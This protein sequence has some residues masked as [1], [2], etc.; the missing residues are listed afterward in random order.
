MTALVAGRDGVRDLVRRSLR[1]RVPARWYAVA[2]LGLP[3]AL[4]FVAPALYGTAPLHALTANWPL[5]FTSFLPTLAFL[6]VFNNVAEEVGW[7][8]FLFA[9]LQDRHRPLGAALLA[10]LPF[11][12]W[13]VLSFTHDTGAWLTGLLIAAFF[14]LPQLASRVMTGWLYNST[15]ASVL[16]AGL[17]HSTFNATVNPG[18]FAVAVLGLP[19]GRWRTSSAAWSSWPRWWSSS[20]RTGSSGFRRPSR[21]Q[22]ARQDARHPLVSVRSRRVRAALQRH[23]RRRGDPRLVAAVGS[24][25]LVTVGDDGYPAATLLPVIWDGDRLVFHM[26]RANP[27]WRSIDEERP[28]WPWSPAPRPTSRRPGTPPR[29][30]TAGWCRPGTT[31]RSTSPA[32]CRHDD[33][34]WLRARSRRLTAST[35]PAGR[36]PGR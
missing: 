33:P 36:S 34:A 16:I 26:A 12:C 10:F 21:R 28:H 1:W 3:A 19:Q 35:R 8:G 32:G 20:R 2:L 25:Q 13:H 18:G 23:R 27:H 11:W 14:A 22:P 9:R 24:A 17:F 5:V 30:S 29:P 4:L 7:T 15:G 6:V 31:R